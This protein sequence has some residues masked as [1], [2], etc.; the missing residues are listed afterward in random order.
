MI[1]K[2]RHPFTGIINTQDD[3]K[4]FNVNFECFIF[5]ENNTTYYIIN[6]GYARLGVIIRNAMHNNSNDFFSRDIP[7]INKC[8]FFLDNNNNQYTC[9]YVVTRNRI[10]IKHE[11]F[12]WSHKDAI[13]AALITQKFKTNL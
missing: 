1:Y 10:R 12:V 3:V 11:T 5:N 4:S 8:I 7:F 2:I 13:N 9:L 6:E